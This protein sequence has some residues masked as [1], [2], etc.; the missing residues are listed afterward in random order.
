MPCGGS[1]P[2]ERR[3]GRQKGTPNK[4]SIGRMKAQLAVSAPEFDPYDRL[5]IIARTLLEQVDAEKRRDRPNMRLVCDLLDKAARVLRDMVPYK[6]ARLS[7]VKV[8]GDE[9]APLFNLSALT[10][11][12]LAFL[13]RTIHKATPVDPGY[14]SNGHSTNC[15]RPTPHSRRIWPET[16]ALNCRPAATNRS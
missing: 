2:G 3:G 1:K 5:E 14:R 13:R 11:N 8:S 12:E 7:A 9:D 6:R 16:L 15:R 10:D 4:L